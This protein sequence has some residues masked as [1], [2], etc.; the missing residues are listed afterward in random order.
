MS[1]FSDLFKGNFGNLGRDITQAPSSLV[2]DYRSEWPYAAAAAALALPFVGPEIGAGFA[3]LAGADAAAGGLGAADAAFGAFDPALFAANAADVAGGG[4]LGADALALAPG[5][6]DALALAEPAAAADPFAAG[7]GLDLTGGS[8][9]GTAASDTAAASPQF[10]AT[11]AELYGGVTG[12]APTA[13]GAAPSTGGGGIMDTLTGALKSPWTKLAIGAAPLALT[14]AR[15]EPSLPSQIGPAQANAAALA[16]QGA[17]LNT[18]QNSVLQ[19]MRQDAVNAARQA[20]FN[21]GVTNPEA[22]SRWPQYVAQIDSQVS[23]AAQ[24]MIQQNIQ[25]SLAGDQQL[26]QI[27]NLQMQSD[28]AFTNNLVRATTALGSAAGLGGG[29]KLVSAA[30]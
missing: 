2:R 25:N 21:Q 11:D 15:G 8:G 7:S 10:A 30:A 9:L 12:T 3:G 17:N 29:L 18:S 20:M 19:Q 26:I 22:D 24:Q 23:A 6:A 5:A 27:A 16:S 28:Q 1:F 13:G 4:A 14:L